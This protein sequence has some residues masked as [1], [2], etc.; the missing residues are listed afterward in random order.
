[1]TNKAL[2]CV[3]WWLTITVLS[4]QIR[5]LPN[6]QV[7]FWYLPT[8]QVSPRNLFTPLETCFLFLMGC[9]PRLIK[10]LRAN[11]TLYICRDKIT[12]VM[13]ALQIKLFMQNEPKFRKVKFNV[14]KVL[15]R[16]YVQLD[17]WSIRKNEPKTNPKRTQTNPILAN[18]TTIR[19]QFKPKQTQSIVSLSNLF[20]SQK[21]LLSGKQK[22]DFVIDFS[23]FCLIMP[24]SGLSC[25]SLS[26]EISLNLCECCIF[27]LFFLLEVCSNYV[28]RL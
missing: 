3:F 26:L 24:G 10:D 2:F 6:Y 20:Q 11:K 28:D 9:N 1:M 8:Y 13:S 22:P 17:T 18:K 19:T 7:S 25:M 4:L 12:D 23:V 15:T 16:D 21:M 14:N 27:N 5:S